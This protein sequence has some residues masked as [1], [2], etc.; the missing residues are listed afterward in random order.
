MDKIYDTSAVHFAP[1]DA[2]GSF[3]FSPHLRSIFYF[4]A[5]TAPEACVPVFRFP[6]L[7]S[8]FTVSHRL[9]HKLALGAAS[10]DQAPGFE[11]PCSPSEQ[12]PSSHQVDHFTDPSPAP[13]FASACD[14]S[15]NADGF[16]GEPISHEEVQV[17][18]YIVRL[19][20]FPSCGRFRLFGSM[21]LLF[22]F[23]PSPPSRRG[24]WVWSRR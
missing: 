9:E 6:V 24:L 10:P 18:S 2:M 19:R 21:S 15:A 23:G 1:G 3:N 12:A 11:V 13:T 5:F 4:P 22:R 20:S 8:A 7:C 14:A 16:S 17:L